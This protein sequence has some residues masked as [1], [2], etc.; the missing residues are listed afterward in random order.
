MTPPTLRAPTFDETV[1]AEN[2]KGASKEALASAN[3]VADK[4]VAASFSFATAYGAVIA[5][6]APEGSPEPIVVAIPFILFAAAAGCA[7][8]AQSEGLA[9]QGTADLAQLRESVNGLIATKRRLSRVALGALVLGVILAGL[10]VRGNYAE[11]AK[12]NAAVDVLVFFSPS[13]R[14]FVQSACGAPFSTLHGT[15]ENTAALSEERVGLAVTKKKCPP[16][17]G[18][19][20]LSQ[21]QIAGV[22]VKAAGNG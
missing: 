8:W 5:L 22:R 10:V 4:L 19:L 7:L 12:A 20:Y 21:R 2:Y 9:L 15:V 18:V 16:Q 3:S 17:G 14:A 13:G 11:P 1:A 6:V